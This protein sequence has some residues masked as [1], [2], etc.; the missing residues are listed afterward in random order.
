MYSYS[1]QQNDT[2][3]NDKINKLWVYHKRS[4]N[5]SLCNTA[6]L[7]HISNR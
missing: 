7:K 4:G 2:K 6:E 5:L 1:V 3:K